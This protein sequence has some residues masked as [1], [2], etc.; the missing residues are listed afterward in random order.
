VLVLR[1][2]AKTCLTFIA[3]FSAVQNESVFLAEDHGI[4]KKIRKLYKLFSEKSQKGE[5]A[6]EFLADIQG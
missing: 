3:D 4:T 1:E 2:A 5:L 6:R